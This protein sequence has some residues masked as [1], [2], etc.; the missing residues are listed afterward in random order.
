MDSILVEQQR[1]T[2]VAKRPGCSP[3]HR[4]VWLRS[5]QDQNVGSVSDK[6]HILKVPK[7]IKY[8]TSN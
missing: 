3:S 6:R 7:L 2:E 1:I 8:P 4:Q 5:S